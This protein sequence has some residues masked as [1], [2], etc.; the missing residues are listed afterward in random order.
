[1]DSGEEDIWA[2][3]CPFQSKPSEQFLWWCRMENGNMS[4]DELSRYRTTKTQ[5]SNKNARGEVLRVY[6]S[7]RDKTLNIN[8]KAFEVAKTTAFSGALCRVKA[9]ETL[10]QLLNGEI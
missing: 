8:G 1:M 5:W 7:H 3:R 6:G 9:Q 2:T 10:K 4:E